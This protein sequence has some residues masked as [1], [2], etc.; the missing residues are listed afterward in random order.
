MSE[1]A[2]VLVTVSNTEEGLKLARGLLEKRL[3][4]CANKVSG[5]RSLY[6][7]EGE[8]CDDGEELLVMKTRAALVPRV[9]K[10]VKELHS[11]SV[12][13]VIALPLL[14]GSEDYLAWVRDNTEDV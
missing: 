12:P 5:V 6:R 7:W 1:F 9:V 14:G 2:V 8:V 4:A 10:R 11:Y 3:I 13:E